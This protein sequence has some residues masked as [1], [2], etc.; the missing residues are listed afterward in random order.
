MNSILEKR[1]YII[2]E[3]N[4][5]QRRLLSILEA[6][7][8]TVPDLWINE[9][10]HGDLDFSVI[11]DMGFSDIKKI[12]L[13]KGEI[14]SIVGIPERITEFQCIDNYITE[15][16]NLPNSLVQ[17]NLDYNYLERIDLKNTPNL[18]KAILS[19]NK[20][21][22]IENLPTSLEELYLNY[23]QIKELDLQHLIQLRVL[24]VKNNK[25]II[26]K[27]IPPSLVNLEMDN[28]PFQPVD[29][30]AVEEDANENEDDTAENEIEYREA[31]NEY[32]K[33]K[34][35]YEEKTLKAKRDAYA[36]GKTKK[37]KRRLVLEVKPK[38]VHC[39]R[40]VGTLF[41][42]KENKYTAICGDRGEPCL[43]NIKI[44]K[45]STMN[46]EEVLYLYKDEVEDLKDDI[47]KQKLDTIFNYL[48]E[49]ESIEQ[50]KKNI[51]QYNYQSSEYNELLAKYDEYYKNPVS[52]EMI[53][54]KTEDIYRLIGAI[55]ELLEEYERTDNKEV[56]KR[57]VEIE[58]QELYPETHNLRMLKYKIMEMFQD[59]KER[60][61]LFQKTIGL[62]EYDYSVGEVPRVIKFRK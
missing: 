47:I 41:S 21:V 48:S 13:K 46:F 53:L 4:T 7:F 29:L 1:E 17:L 60:D 18:K 11:R 61:I 14:T 51:T 32:F 62:G 30:A 57:I 52:K 8:K 16:N 59:K 31:L 19:H 15:I 33:M 56:L 23:N 39:K 45:G 27:N 38:C 25:S 26:L 44:Y 55:R 28:D 58:N 42:L 43:L 12:F 34:Q 20:L 54:K 50:F 9:A 49:K 36:L 37:E 10:L 24:H 40:P 5:A 35:Q 3:N 2:N 6:L 22:E